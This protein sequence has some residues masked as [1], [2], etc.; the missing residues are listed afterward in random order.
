[1]SR[2]FVAVK[3]KPWDRRTYTY[4]NDGD[5]VAVGDLVEVSTDRG[6]QIVTVESVTFDAPSFV[7]KPINGPASN[8]DA[9]A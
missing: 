6:E 2:Q 9:A 1:M 7:T 5:P 3:F 4:H 8:T